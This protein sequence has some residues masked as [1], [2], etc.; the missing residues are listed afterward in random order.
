MTV[1]YDSSQLFIIPIKHTSEQRCHE[2]NTHPYLI[3]NM[4]STEP[5]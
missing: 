5:C 1:I 4:L 3:R 2:L